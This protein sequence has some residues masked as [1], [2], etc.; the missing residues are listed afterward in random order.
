MDNVY[1]PHSTVPEARKYS[2]AITTFEIMLA[3]RGKGALINYF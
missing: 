1:I 3:K 2:I